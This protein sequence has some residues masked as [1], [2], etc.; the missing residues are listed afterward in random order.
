MGR[1][2]LAVPG[3]VTSVHSTGCHQLIRDGVARLVTDATD[4]IAEL[5][6]TNLA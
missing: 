3:P 1:I 2:V 6:T 4:I 5:G